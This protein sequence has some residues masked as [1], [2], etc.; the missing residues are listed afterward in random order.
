MFVLV[1]YLVQAAGYPQSKWVAEKNVAQFCEKLNIPYI[2]VRPGM[3][4]WSTKT[5]VLTDT[6]WFSRLIRGCSYIHAAPESYAEFSLV[7]VDFMAEAIVTLSL[8]KADGIS[9][10]AYYNV[11]NFFPDP[12][13]SLLRLMET[14][15][16]DILV[17]KCPVK[18]PRLADGL[19]E[20]CDT[21]SLA[22]WNDVIATKL[23]SVERGSHDEEVLSGLRM[24]RNGLPSDKSV[25]S[26]SHDV[27]CPLL[28]PLLTME[29]MM[30]M[31]KNN[32]L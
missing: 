21:V 19:K 3:T 31:I 1:S 8:G 24:F 12:F 22:V 16:R 15:A 25:F 10:K 20:I 23:R 4:S 28:Y 11:F 5:G 18:D 26:P 2:I 29:Y 6:D 27:C 9:K 32:V 13:Y 30:V 17:K 14:A 7:P